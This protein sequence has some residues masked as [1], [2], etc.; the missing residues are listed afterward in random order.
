MLY[1]LKVALDYCVYALFKQALS[2]ERITRREFDRLEKSVQFPI[3]D[4]PKKLRAW[5]EKHWHWLRPDERAVI[6][7]AQPYRRKSMHFLGDGYHNLDKHRDLQPLV[8]DVDLTGAR[9]REIPELRTEDDVQAEPGTM[10]RPVAVYVNG[11]IEIRFSDRS[12]LIE[13]LEVL[14]SE[15][16]ALIDAFGLA[17]E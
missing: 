6:R 10:S 4:T 11:A 1:N 9:F 3:M 13:T 15:V 5:R 8:L 2:A 14:E 12:P 7:R 17:F 16:R